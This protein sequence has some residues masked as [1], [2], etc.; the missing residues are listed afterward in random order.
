[1]TLLAAA[2]AQALKA[3]RHSGGWI[4]PCPAHNDRDPSLTIRDGRNG[5]LLHC[6]SGCTFGS[7]VD[8]LKRLGVSDDPSSAPTLPPHRHDA[9]GGRIGSIE[10]ALRIWDQA[11]ALGYEGKRYLQRRGI[12]KAPGVQYLRQATLR[13]PIGVD[14][15]AIITS[16]MN[17]RDKPLGIQRTFI[18]EADCTKFRDGEAK[19]SLGEGLFT[20]LGYGDSIFLAEGVENALSAQMLFGD[21]PA[22]ACCMGFPKK[23]VELP[24][25]KRIRLIVDHD[26]HG[27][28]QK[29]ALVFHELNKERYEIR[30]WIPKK[31][32]Q[33][34][35]DVWLEHMK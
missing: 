8:A 16:R 18:D 14:A 23:P 17:E 22:F 12:L 2:V 13:H 33:D 21:F 30:Q 31:P 34:A 6:W 5:I 25:V 19:L 15:P 9:T 24:G 29:K 7:I 10:A 28:S 4:A 3:R 20:M 1:M 26:R 32:G 11:G 27:A 35:N